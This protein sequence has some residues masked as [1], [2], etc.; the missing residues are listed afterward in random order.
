MAAAGVALVSPASAFASESSDLD[1]A[2]RRWRGARCRTRMEIAVKKGTDG[3]GWSRS[4][5]L[6]YSAKKS[7]NER[8]LVLVKGADA[9]RGRYAGRT[10]PIGVELVAA[11]WATDGEDG[12]GDLY[13]ELEHPEIG[14]RARVYYY[15]SWV[16]RV[17]VKRLPE[18]ERWARLELLEI[19]STPE[20]QL[21]DVPS[22]PP[23]AA[24]PVAIAS[25]PAARPPVEVA[26]AVDVRVLAASV[27]PA[28]VPPGSEA[29][30]RIVYSVSGLAPGSE[31][32]VAEERVVTRDGT[33]LTTLRAEAR[34][35]AGVHQSIQNLRLPVD[36]APGV[37]ELQARV[38]AGGQTATGTA[39]FQVQVPGSP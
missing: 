3:D 31:T 13:L 30:F 29:G 32:I 9:L 18:F 27:E 39:M 25:P 2:N 12:G 6:W 5:W 16:G 36:L 10:L 19:V 24:P 11:G 4:E 35:A 8:V 23:V 17:S 14:V 22:S 37:Y 33:V 1:A 7:G 26:G 21:V 34:R 15:A 28:R 20:E 38:S